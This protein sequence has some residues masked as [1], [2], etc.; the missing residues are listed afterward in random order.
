MA[1]TKGLEMECKDKALNSQLHSNRAAVSMRMK[2]NDKA[3]DDCRRAIE[4]DPKNTKAWYRGAKASEALGL[5]EQGLKFCKGALEASPDDEQ[6][7]KLQSKFKKQFA[8][9]QEQ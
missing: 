4:L 6:L 2:A 9:E 5:T 7:K 1:Y 3:I 8:Q